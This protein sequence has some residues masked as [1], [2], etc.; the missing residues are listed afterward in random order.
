MSFKEKL[1][2][3]KSEFSSAVQRA[4]NKLSRRK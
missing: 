1:D 2:A 3:L 4:R